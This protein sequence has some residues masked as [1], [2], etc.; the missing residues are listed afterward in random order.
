MIFNKIDDCKKPVDKLKKEGFFSKL[1][2][3]CTSDDQIQRTKEL[4]EIF[5][6]K[7]GEEITKLYLK[8]D[9]IFLADFFEHFIK[10]SIEDYGNNPLYCV[11]L[12]GY[13]YP[14]ALKYTYI[15]LQA[16]QEKDLILLKENNLRG[17]ISSV[18]GDR[19]VVS[20]DNKTILYVDATNLYGHSMSQILPFDEIEMWYGHSDLYRN[21]L[22]EII[23][24]PDQSDIDY[25]VEFDLKSP[26]EKKRKQKLSHLLL[27]MKKNQLILV[28]K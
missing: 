15:I 3:E 16:L 25:F 22:E 14:C 5:D 23:N 13:T 6:N 8:G 17:G 12:P 18:M 10:V 27:K 24:T 4:I 21:K 9:I 20:D 28:I 1:T 26:D 7:N 2:S 11:S 19:Y